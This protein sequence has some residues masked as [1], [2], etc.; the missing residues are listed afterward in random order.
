L[1]TVEVSG[2]GEDAEAEPE[3]VRKENAEEDKEGGEDGRK[4]EGRKQHRIVARGY[5]KFFNI[6]EVPWTTV[7]HILSPSS[8]SILTLVR[9]WPAL[10]AHTAP[11][12]TLSLKSNGCIIFIAALTPTRILVTSKHSI[13]AVPGAKSTT[14]STTSAATPG[15]SQPETLSHAQA[16][17]AWLRKY[18]AQKGRTETE[19]AGKLWRE[20]WTAVAEVCAHF[21]LFGFPLLLLLLLPLCYA[22]RT[23]ARARGTCSGTRA[24]SNRRERVHARRSEIRD[25]GGR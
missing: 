20:K 10:E 14:Q 9:Q 17:E 25:K 6:G 5:D 18:L 4:K 15:S 7:R 13:G 8:Q 22:F 2:E 23:G 24:T 11:P 19:L 3:P 1:F 21:Q 16:G 12:Y